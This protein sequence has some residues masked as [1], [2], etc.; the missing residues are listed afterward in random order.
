[1]LQTTFRRCLR[2]INGFAAARKW[3]K[4]PKVNLDHL[5][6]GGEVAEVIDGH[7][8]VIQRSGSEVFNHHTLGEK[9]G[10]KDGTGVQQASI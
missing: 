10:E 1:M 7:A 9:H 4:G 5:M 8:P 6:H 2:L 3:F